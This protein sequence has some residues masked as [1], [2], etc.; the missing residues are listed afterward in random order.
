LNDDKGVVDFVL[1]VESMH[2]IIPFYIGYMGCTLDHVQAALFTALK[3]TWL[4]QRKAVLQQDRLN[5]FLRTWGFILYEAAAFCNERGITSGHQ[6]LEGTATINVH[7][8]LPAGTT[9]KP[10][11][12]VF[13]AARHLLIS[14]F[15]DSTGSL[16]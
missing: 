3:E 2:D 11:T 16:R 15:K 14:A 9:P 8:R 12:K 10:Q 7:G 13:A 6:Q 4:K 5:K 1:D